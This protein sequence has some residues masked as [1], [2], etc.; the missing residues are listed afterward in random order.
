MEYPGAFNPVSQQCEFTLE[1][2]YKLAD[3]FRAP[4]PGELVVH[5]DYK[6]GDI[7]K[8]MEPVMAVCYKAPRLIVKKVK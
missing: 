1:E 7:A 8:P 5:T 4:K 2:G 6:F 3:E